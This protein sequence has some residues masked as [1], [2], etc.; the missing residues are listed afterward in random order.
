MGSE[1]ADADG[2]LGER[3][4]AGAA[5][6]APSV[7]WKMRSG[8]MP[9]TTIS[10]SIGVQATHSGTWTSWMWACSNSSFGVPKAV[11]WNIHSR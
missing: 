9:R 1:P 5:A 10:T 3:D 4:G 7:T 8:K 2:G 6:T 11:R